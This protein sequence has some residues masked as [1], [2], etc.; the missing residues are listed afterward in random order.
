MTTTT[1]VASLAGKNGRLAELHTEYATAD[2]AIT[3]ARKTA[4]EQYP[5][6]VVIDLRTKTTTTVGALLGYTPAGYAW[7]DPR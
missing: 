3:A 4:H 6:A 5:D 1:Y 2:E 7:V